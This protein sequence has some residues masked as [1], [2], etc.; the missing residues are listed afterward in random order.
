MD[1]PK[2]M[3]DSNTRIIFFLSMLAFSM[4]PLKQR[5]ANNMESKVRGSWIESKSTQ[6]VSHVI[7][8]TAKRTD[9]MNPTFLS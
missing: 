8:I 9:A 3:P 4:W 1:N 2:N 5:T 6:R 7:G